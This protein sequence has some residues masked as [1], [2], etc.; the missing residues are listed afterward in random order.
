MSMAT[1]ITV[2]AESALQTDEKH[3]R[4]LTRIL[5]QIH[6]FPDPSG[7]PVGTT[8]R[9]LAEKRIQRLAAQ[10]ECLGFE[11]TGKA[12][13]KELGKKLALHSLGL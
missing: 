8:Q 2:W 10:A 5:Q 3:Q 11:T 7:L 9:L 12:I 4:E 1:D 6:A 13:R